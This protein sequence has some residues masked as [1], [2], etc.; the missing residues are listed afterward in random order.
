MA[1]RGPRRT[2]G[3]HRTRHATGNGRRSR[4]LVRHSKRYSCS[5]YQRAQL[6]EINTCCTKMFRR[7][8]EPSSVLSES[9]SP[10]EA[11]AMANSLLQKV[12]MLSGMSGEEWFFCRFAGLPPTIRL[13]ATSSNASKR[14]AAEGSRAHHKRAVSS[15]SH[16]VREASPG[17]SK[18][19]GAE[20]VQACCCSNVFVVSL[21][22]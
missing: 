1:S 14:R 18:W 13:P 15:G 22:H 7:L 6:C 19:G 21:P 11:I 2:R 12:R 16:C 20:G 3:R 9:R 8:N 17:G 5:W 4:G 10:V